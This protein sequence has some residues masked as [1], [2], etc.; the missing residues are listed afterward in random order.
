[1]TSTFRLA[2]ALVGALLLSAV[3]IGPASAQAPSGDEFPSLTLSYRDRDGAGTIQFTNQG[4]DAASGGSRLGVALQQNAR[5]FSGEGFA[6][7]LDSA[8]FI[9]SFWLT[10]GTGTDYVFT[11]IFVRGFAGW[12]AEGRYEVVGSPGVGDHWSMASAPCPVC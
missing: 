2:A 4:I 11:G 8:T 9:G 12:T 7:R 10:D 5:S 1:M 6:R 3:A